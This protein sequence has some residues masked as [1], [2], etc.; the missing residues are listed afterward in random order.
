M[1]GRVGFPSVGR[2]RA[3]GRQRPGDAGAG[4]TLR[5]NGRRLTSMGGPLSERLWVVRPTLTIQGPVMAE[6]SPLR[7]RMI[8]DMTIRNPT[9]RV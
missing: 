8:E 9:H 2:W 4:K 7:R 1:G 5:A 6:V 3:G